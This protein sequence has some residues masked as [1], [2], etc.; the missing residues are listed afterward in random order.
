MPLLL[1]KIYMCFNWLKAI[2]A[3]AQGN[4]L[5]RNAISLI[6]AE[7]PQ[8]MVANALSG[9]MTVYSTHRALPCANAQWAFSPNPIFD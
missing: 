1:S 8:A 4:A 6:R 2:R 9:R 5:C 3:L 7:S